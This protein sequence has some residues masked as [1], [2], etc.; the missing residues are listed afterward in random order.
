MSQHIFRSSREPIRKRLDL[1]WA[2]L[3]KGY[4]KGLIASWEI[5][6]ELREKKPALATC[7]NMGELPSLGWKGGVEKKIKQKEKYGTLYYLATWQ[8]LRGDDLDIDL[9]GERPLICSR[10]G[11]K[12]ICTG[13]FKKYGNS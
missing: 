5:G 1:T 3:W 6:R 8:G 12:V 10:T 9:S 11:M 7:A 4:D 13:D 2:E